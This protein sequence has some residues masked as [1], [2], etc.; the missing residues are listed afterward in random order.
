MARVRGQK[1]YGAASEG[2][3][4]N[5]STQRN[6]QI[7]N[8][9]P[10]GGGA[11]RLPIRPKIE[12]ITEEKDT[13]QQGNARANIASMY[14][15]K[16]APQVVEVE[17]QSEQI[18]EV[19]KL[20]PLPT[21]VK[22]LVIPAPA[23]LPPLVIAP[24]KDIGVQTPMQIKSNVNLRPD[25]VT[26]IL[27]PGGVVLE[28][29][30][31]DGK[32]VVDPIK[33]VG[34]DPKDPP[35]SIKQLREDFAE[36]VATGKD[37][38]GEV[39]EAKPETKKLLKQDGLERFIPK[40]LKKVIESNT[41]NEDGGTSGIAK[42]KII[43]TTQAQ[44]K[45]KPRD[46]VATITEVMDSN[47]I[48]VNL[49]YNEGVNLY[50]HKGDDEV[51]NKFKNFR[52]NYIKNNIERYKTYMVKDNQ[53]YL[54]TNE[55]LGASGKERFIKLKQP[56]ENCK[57]DDKVIFVEKRL[58]D[59]K[60]IVT[61]NP[62]TETENDS[63]FL[64]I[65]NLN[66]VDNP[67][68]FQGT[69]YKTHDGLLSNKDDDARD[70]ERLLISGS[71]LDVQPNIDY[72]KTTT[73]LSI[74]ND[75]TGFGNFVNF[76][77]A[78]RRITNFKDKLI[79]I[80]SH[81]AASAS[82]TTI[83]SSADT[84]L[85]LQRKK[86]RVINSFDPYE[87]YLY[88]ESSSYVSSS[89]GQ[90]HDTA[91]PKSNSSSP[92]TL[93]STG[94]ASSWYNAMVASAS[95][96]DQGN[97]DS[98]RNSLPLH[99]NQDSENNVFLEFM[100]MVGQQFDEI[101]T[102]TK[103]ITDINMR[104]EKISEGISKDV[105]Q[106]YA[107]ALGLNL[108]SGND[109]V[110]LPEYLLGND[111]DG[112]SLYDSP[113]EKVTEEIWKRILANLPYFIKSKGT[114]RALKGLLNC[115]GIPSSILRVREYGGPDKGTRVNYE[116][117]RKFTRATDFRAAQYIKSHWKA[118]ADGQVPDTIE[119]RFRTPKS[120]DTIIVQKDNDFA[121]SL[122]DNGESDD[123]G[124][125]RFEISGA[126][127]VY[128]Q[129]ITSSLLPLYNDDFWSVMLTRKD[130]DGN[131]IADDKILSQ[132]VYELTTKQYDSTKQRIL[133]QSSESLQTHTSS[134]AT[135]VNNITGSSL[136]AAFTGSGHL[137]IGGS[138][139]AF[140]ANTFTGSLME[141]R[142]WSE[143]LSSSAFDN[144]VRAPKA[145]NGNSISSSYNDLLVRYQL[146]D[147]VDLSS[148]PTLSNA[149]HLQTYELGTSGSDV[150]G[151]T[152]NFSRTLVDQE[153]LRVPDI[154]GVR[155]NATKIRIEDTTITQP[156]V[157]NV[158]KEKSSDDFAPIDS[159]KLGIYFAP[160]DVVNEDIMYSVADFDFDDYIGDPRDE[161]R[162]NYPELRSI[163][164][165]YFKRYTN[166]N[167]FFDY[168]RILSF[169]DS[170]VFTQVKNLVPA[171]A[172]ASVGILIEP[173]ILERS[174]QIIGDRPEF[175][176]RYYENANH[177]EDGIKVTRYISGSDD[178]YFEVSGEYNTYNGEINLN[179][180]TGSSLGFLNQ[181]SLMVLDALDP[182]SEFGSLYATASV[183]GGGG[184]S[185]K[186]FTEVLQPNITASRTSENNQE[187]VFFYSSSLSASIG[188]T[189]SYSSSFINSDV[190]SV[191]YDSP[192][193]R[194]FYLG[195][196]LTRDN[197]IDGKEPIEVNQVSPT[198]IVTQDSD[199]TKLRTD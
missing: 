11:P 147:N 172:K 74:E 40:V 168:L 160:T 84:R 198:T 97:M 126:S 125:L 65:P 92:Y 32:V 53:Y 54:I 37:E 19:I 87:H 56:A 187:A 183:E 171:R 152:A 62:F 51:A 50:Q 3:V 105:A 180:S 46:Y 144:H 9:A 63:L 33:D 38:A 170:S 58:P 164:R 60:D 21:P 89:D 26:E 132:S 138:G 188:T 102:Y 181:R 85:D 25:G 145:Y 8:R 80:E 55:E 175:D 112:A 68:D 79:L 66:S 96:Y 127:A 159:N 78:E 151:F 23:V 191:A 185:N 75:D 47:R 1:T 90:F 48:R 116:I 120:Q 31:G 166:T 109:L 61:L 122:Q 177:F 52:V 153:K 114:E 107:R 161:F 99:I 190:Q 18:A 29:I 139:S 130:T 184:T 123:Y 162:V 121:I 95:S 82:L 81:S 5:G 194:T 91:W 156:L 20:Q 76:S 34:F 157:Y 143:P 158:R 163:R 174:K 14:K 117:K 118:A 113:Q 179:N 150:N 167:N 192:L 155:R 71:L 131:E 98:L 101:W 189:L 2:N 67:I 136:N 129:F 154:G 86:Q 142:V 93:E 83:S 42:E 197:T 12:Q 119:F 186:I 140:G 108:S 193:F 111:V 176:N 70:I 182:R 165:E 196:K 10:A 7:S 35:V 6:Q 128:D 45:L 39:F 148:S 137:Y 57:V 134:L 133:F 73:D 104:V 110:N 88:F 17:I 15:P 72:Q 59:Y 106:N 49:S 77:S 41:E 146:N 13:S 22:P 178:N 169:Y 36:H 64:R 103:S 149:A 135:D 27:G 141:F 173:N 16:P 30:G 44:A 69:N 43:T 124:F 115:Y 199:I 4:E 28:E 94:D 24:T 100:D 195:T